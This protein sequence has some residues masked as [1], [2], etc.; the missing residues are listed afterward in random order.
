MNCYSVF[1]IDVFEKM[2][3]LWLSFFIVFNTNFNI[4]NVL[5]QLFLKITMHEQKILF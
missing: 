1:G 2:V 5:S 3:N 4:L